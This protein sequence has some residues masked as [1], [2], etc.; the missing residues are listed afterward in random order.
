MKERI[1]IRLTSGCFLLR[2]GCQGFFASVRLHNSVCAEVLSL[3]YLRKRQANSTF[4]F[5]DYKTKIIVT[6]CNLIN[7]LLSLILLVWTSILD[8]RVSFPYKKRK[9]MY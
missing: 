3:V 2:R 8:F 5:N 4:G 1:I 9:S 6:F 7:Q